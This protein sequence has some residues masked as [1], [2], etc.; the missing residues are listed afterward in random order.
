MHTTTRETA[1]AAQRAN[2]IHLQ[3]VEELNYLKTK[4]D[5]YQ[6][7]CFFCLTASRDGNT[8]H[9]DKDSQCL[10]KSRCFLC[11]RVNTVCRYSTCPLNGFR[12]PNGCFNCLLPQ[13]THDKDRVMCEKYKGCLA[14]FCFGLT[15]EPD[16]LGRLNERFSIQF[17]KDDQGIRDFRTWMGTVPPDQSLTNAARVFKWAMT[18]NILQL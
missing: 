14:R 7:N 9:S 10:V 4:L 17:G 8:R 2:V 15:Y 1:S 6:N 18:E 16:R 13:I 5:L 3:G 11:L 12:L